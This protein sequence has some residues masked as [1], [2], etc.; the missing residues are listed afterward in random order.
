MLRAAR[1]KWCL[2]L[3]AA[4]LPHRRMLRQPAETLSRGRVNAAF[5][6]AKPA[7]IF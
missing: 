3:A 7:D 6:R 1:A 4:A 2:N 5:L